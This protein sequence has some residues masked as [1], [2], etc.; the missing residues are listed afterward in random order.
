MNGWL[1]ILKHGQPR[2]ILKKVG[3]PADAVIFTDGSTEDDGTRPTIG[4]VSFMWWKESPAHR[5]TVSDRCN[6]DQELSR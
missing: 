3:G 5:V 2:P 4:G 1:R 6:D